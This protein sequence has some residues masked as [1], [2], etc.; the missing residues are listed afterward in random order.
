MRTE[1][2]GGREV[3]PAQE[4]ESSLGTLMLEVYTRFTT[5]TLTETSDSLK[6]SWREQH[7]Y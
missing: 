5:R 6:E 2:K 4:P 3:V 7:L 1:V